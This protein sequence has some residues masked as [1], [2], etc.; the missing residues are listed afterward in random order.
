MTY[1]D[2]KFVRGV[3]TDLIMVSGVSLLG[4]LDTYTPPCGP[5]GGDGT[6]VNEIVSENLPRS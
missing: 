2:G 6:T 1:G 4:T 3:V 5:G